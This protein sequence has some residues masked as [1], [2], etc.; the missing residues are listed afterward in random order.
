MQSSISDDILNLL[1]ENENL[2]AQMED[3]FRKP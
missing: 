1:P 3:Y 2:K